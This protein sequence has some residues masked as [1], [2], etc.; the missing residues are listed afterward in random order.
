VIVADSN[1]TTSF[2]HHRPV[3]RPSV[4]ALTGPC[5]RHL[6]KSIREDPHTHTYT[7]THKHKQAYVHTRTNKYTC[8]YAETHRHVLVHTTV[9]WNAWAEPPS[10]PFQP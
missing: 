4:V 1:H 7:H 6:D 5:T 2:H 8:T 9:T 10:G 3:L